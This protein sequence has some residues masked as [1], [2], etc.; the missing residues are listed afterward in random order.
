MQQNVSP[1]QI[2]REEALSRWGCPTELLLD[3][4]R[5]HQSPAFRQVLT[6][7]KD[8]GGREPEPQS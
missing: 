4:D 1:T 3:R 8:G 6:G 5:S 2:P 7:T